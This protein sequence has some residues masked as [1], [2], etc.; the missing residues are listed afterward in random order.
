M[1]GIRILCDTNPLI[2]LLD[3]NRDIADFLNNK[4]IYVSVITELELFGKKNLSKQDSKI[5]E[6]LLESCFI[7]NINQEI[8]Q[9][10]KELKQKYSV[11]L[12]DAIVAATSI[13]LDMP[14]LTFDQGFKDISELQL[15]LWEG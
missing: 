4:Q 5:I 9:T 6:A 12:P 15:I 7:I 11:K 8:K 13:Y 1:S 3:G 14:L 2:Y 10:Y